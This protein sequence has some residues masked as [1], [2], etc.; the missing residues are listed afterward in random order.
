[1][2]FKEKNTLAEL[3]GNKIFIQRAPDKRFP[4]LSGQVP[5][6]WICLPT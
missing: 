6:Y 4:S 5:K 3:L 1:M 2:T